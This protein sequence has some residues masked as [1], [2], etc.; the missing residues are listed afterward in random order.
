MHWQISKNIF[1]DNKGEYLVNKNIA[2][3]GFMGTGKTTI[4]QL[5]AI[6]LKVNSIDIDAL[7]EEKSGM[8]IVDIFAQKGEP[9]FRK[10]EK[11]IVADIS[12]ETGKILAC[13]GGVV[14]DESNIQNL[15]K[16][17]IIICLKARPEIILD[18]TKAYAQ[19]PLLNVD[20]PKA[21]ISELLKKRHKFYAKADYT[22]DTSDLNKAEVVREIMHKIKGKI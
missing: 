12:K 13:G 11:N 22:I 1:F 19:R 5:L 20:N 3:V 9:F 21:K 6:E 15:K 4:A 8:K 14:L 18:R 17:G 2:L 16:N 7:I 10:L